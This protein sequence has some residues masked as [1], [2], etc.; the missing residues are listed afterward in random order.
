MRVRLAVYMLLSI[1]NVRII[2][3]FNFILRCIHSCARV[4]ACSN[5]CVM[6]LFSLQMKKFYFSLLHTWPF[7]PF[8]RHD[9]APSGALACFIFILLLLLLSFLLFWVFFAAEICSSLFYSPF[10]LTFFWT[11]ACNCFCYCYSLLL[12][13]S[14]QHTCA[15]I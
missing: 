15:C 4:F 10:L 11:V 12:G 14:D 6:C 5:V 1:P 2:S 13:T 8:R 3:T 7:W 9:T